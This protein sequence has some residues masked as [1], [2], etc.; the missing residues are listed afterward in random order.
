MAEPTTADATAP[1][2]PHNNTTINAID[3]ATITLQRF[4][5]LDL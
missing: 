2:K 4:D 1:T 3:D 5:L